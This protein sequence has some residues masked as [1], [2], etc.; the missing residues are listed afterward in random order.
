VN[1]KFWEWV[2]IFLFGCLTFFHFRGSDTVSKDVSPIVL[3]GEES[4]ML[5]FIIDFQD[6]SCP[7]CLDSFLGLFHRLPSRYR[8]AKAWGILAVDTRGEEQEVNRTIR[9]A[10]KKLRGFIQ[11]NQITFPFLVD[12]SQVFGRL[13]KEGSAVVLLD[14]NQKAVFRY[15]FPLTGEEFE[16][17]FEVLN[18]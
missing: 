8:T 14:E 6:F 2:V 15:Y 7:T 18:E 16:K 13:A 1:L 17:I 9:I 10:E 11:A 3:S 12:R 5:L 4:R